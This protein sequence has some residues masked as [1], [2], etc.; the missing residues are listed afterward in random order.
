MKFAMS[1]W[2]LEKELIFSECV[3]E[4]LSPLFDHLTCEILKKDSEHI[5]TFLKQNCKLFL[6]VIYDFPASYF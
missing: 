3:S 1:F 2:P 6:Q 5:I 4:Y